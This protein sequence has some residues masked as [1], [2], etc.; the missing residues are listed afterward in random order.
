MLKWLKITVLILSLVP[1]IAQAQSFYSF[2]AV[3]RNLMVSAGSGVATYKGE[4]VDP[5]ELGMARAN[6]AFGA[7]YFVYPRISARANLTWFQLSGDDAKANDS[8]IERNLHFRSNN[9]E[10]SFTG[11]VHLFPNGPRFY[12][13]P[14]IHVYGFAGFGLLY[15]NPKAEYQGEWVALQPLQTEGTKYSRFTPVIPMGFG[16]KIKI[17]PFWN[18]VIEGGYRETFTDHLDDVSRNNYLAASELKSDLARALA[19][20]RNE[21]GTLPADRDPTTFGRRGNPS[22][23][24]SYIILNVSIQYYLPKELF[25]SQRK[26]Y[27]RKRRSI[28]NRSKSR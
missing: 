24:D 5:G 11:A 12:Q 13:R 27:N 28:Y 21:I 4:M 17:D 10:L 16:A 3:N 2:R 8:R 22:R 23:D 25:G 9:V 14:S 15:F 19:D 7:E 18:I 20:R 26:L 1:F 6:I